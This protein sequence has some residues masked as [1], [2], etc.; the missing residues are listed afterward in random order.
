MPKQFYLPRRYSNI[1]I[2]LTTYK[3]R[4]TD[5]AAALGLSAAEVTEQTDIVDS[6]VQSIA[7]AA[8]AKTAAKAATAK[9]RTAFTKDLPK[10][11]KKINN[12][13]TRST[14]TEAVGE[15]MGIE[16]PVHIIDEDNYKPALKVQAFA[17]HVEVK[18]KK[19]GVT[20]MKIFM[21]LPGQ[22]EWTLAATCTRSPFKHKL[23]NLSQGLLEKREY[24]AMGLIKDVAIGQRSDVVNVVVQG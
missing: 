4:L 24:S 14:Y 11:L 3:K 8:K 12:I 22:T 6:V 21:R 15:G 17:D 2:W 5:N 9:K 16:G 13:K 19:R 7:D 18:F 20:S 1:S 23:E 10:L